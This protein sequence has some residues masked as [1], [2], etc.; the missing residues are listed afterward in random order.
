MVNQD[1]A[2]VTEGES[3]FNGVLAKGQVG[4]HVNIVEDGVNVRGLAENKLG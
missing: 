4:Y 3:C 2:C 1:V